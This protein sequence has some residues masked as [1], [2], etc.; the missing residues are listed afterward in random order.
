MDNLY[1]KNILTKIIRENQTK[2]SKWVRQ[3]DDLNNY[4]VTHPRIIVRTRVDQERM[5]AESNNRFNYYVSLYDCR[6]CSVFK[7]TIYTRID[8]GNVKFFVF[9]VDTII[10]KKSSRH[11]VW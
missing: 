6:S 11:V 10:M 7:R 9:V 2:F 1:F 8:F 5:D 3:T 4:S